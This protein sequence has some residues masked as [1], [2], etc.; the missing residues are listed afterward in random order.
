MRI[1]DLMQAAVEA[2]ADKLAL[3]DFDDK[4]VSWRALNDAAKAA[5]EVLK[6][7]GVRPGDR[8]VIVLENSAVMVAY[9]FAASMIDAIAV[10]INARLSEAEIDRIVGH[11][12]AAA[13]VLTVETGSAPA[14]QAEAMKQSAFP[15]HWAKLRSWRGQALRPSPFMRMLSGKWR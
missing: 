8:V 5:C 7:H 13:V 10:P 3:V 11:C 6:T 14:A 15:A 12:D 4:R 2:R 1:H 9:L